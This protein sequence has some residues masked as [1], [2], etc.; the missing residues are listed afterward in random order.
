MPRPRR[1]PGIASPDQLGLG[2][3]GEGF[4]GPL[5][6][7]GVFSTAY[8][9][10]NLRNA[11]QFASETDSAQ[12]FRE[13]VEIWRERVAALSRPSTNEAFTCSELIEPILDRLGW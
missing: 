11:S 1:S 4:E 3:R 2:L 10:R 9:A 7:R 12:P 13:I 8:L 6:A 5:E